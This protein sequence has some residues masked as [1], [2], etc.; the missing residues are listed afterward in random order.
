MNPEQ[1]SQVSLL[2]LWADALADESVVIALTRIAGYYARV[3]LVQSGV[4]I[5]HWHIKGARP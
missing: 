2:E 3:D 5:T 4:R 1:E